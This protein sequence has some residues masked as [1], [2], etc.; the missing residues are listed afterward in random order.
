MQVYYILNNGSLYDRTQAECT[1]VEAWNEYTGE[2][3]YAP[4]TQVDEGVG[5]F[6]LRKEYQNV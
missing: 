4:L 1:E 5:G 3:V 2:Y 6:I